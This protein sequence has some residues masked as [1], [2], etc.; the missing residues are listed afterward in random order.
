MY[1][2]RHSYKDFTCIYEEIHISG[3][4]HIRSSHGYI[5]GF[6]YREEF[7]LGVHIY[8]WRDSYIRTNSY[9]EFTYI[10]GGIDKG[11]SYISMEE[12]ICREGFI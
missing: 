5:Q 6:I 1:V 11:S 10:Y 4:I 12:F 9:K 3:G 8:L 7:I 2:W